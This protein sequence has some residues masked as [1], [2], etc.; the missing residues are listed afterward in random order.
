MTVGFVFGGR[1]PD[2]TGRIE[3]RTQLVDLVHP[4]PSLY[5]YAIQRSFRARCLTAV[6]LRTD[7]PR[8]S[9]TSELLVRERVARCRLDV[10]TTHSEGRAPLSLEINERSSEQAELIENKAKL[11]KITSAV[12]CHT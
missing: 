9:F 2:L 11:S 7:I 3:A 6:A 10:N 8:L 12:L 5:E 1:G 4:I